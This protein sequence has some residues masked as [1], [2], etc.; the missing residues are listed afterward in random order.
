MRVIE[1]INYGHLAA[2]L[3]GQG[4]TESL[5]PSARLFEHP[6]GA[7]LILPRLSDEEPLR[8]HHYAAAQAMVS[9]YHLL[10]RDAFDLLLLQTARPLPVTV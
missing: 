1:G 10:T 7:E 8:S 4:F 3:R 6:V 5:R 2:V 9:D